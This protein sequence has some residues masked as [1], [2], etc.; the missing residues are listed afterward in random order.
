[1][2]IQPKVGGWTGV[3]NEDLALRLVVGIEAAMLLKISAA[4]NLKQGSHRCFTYCERV[5]SLA[6]GLMNIS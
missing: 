3:P 1:M 2:L 4:E 6:I 5:L